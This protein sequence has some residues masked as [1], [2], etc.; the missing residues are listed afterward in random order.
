[1]SIQEVA[2]L[3]GVSAA[4]VSRAFNF[5]D[6]VQPLTQARVTAAAKALGYVPN[7][8]A[9]SLRT[10]RSRV[11]GVVLPTLLNPVFAECLEG[12]AMA[13]A[14]AGYAIL[15]VT[16]H[17]SLEDENKAI[18]QL[19]GVNVEG[20]ILVVSNPGKSVA[21]SRLSDLRRPYVLAYNRHPA[22]PCVSVDGE[23]AVAAMVARL[24]G[25]GHQRILMM[26]GQLQTS[27]RAQQRCQGYLA[28]MRSQGLGE[29]QVLEVPFIDSAIDQITP[30]LLSAAKPTAVICSNDLLALRC[31]RAA[32]KAGLRVPDDLSVV[33]F[34]GIAVGRDLTPSLCTISQPN[35]EIGQRCTELLVAALRD[36]RPLTPA[37]SLTLPHRFVDGESCGLAPPNLSQPL[38]PKELLCQSV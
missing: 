18:D 25:W 24:A 4:T 1:M 8:S 33:G 35:A 16:T 2:K 29:G 26:A 7:A 36:D 27:D 5:P 11:I 22:Q 20:L 30:V 28:A 19:L 31:V 3:A 9:R 12:I 14:K 10:Q 23:Q 34:D 13:A 32:H 37:S 21:L 17:Y 6:R 38:N 15:P